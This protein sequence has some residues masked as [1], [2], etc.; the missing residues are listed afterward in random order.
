M[1]VLFE[2]LVIVLL[3]TAGWRQSFREHAIRIFPNAAFASKKSIYR[4]PPP[5]NII[6]PQPIET[7]PAPDPATSRRD[8]SWLWDKTPLDRR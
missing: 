6:Y 2:I 5:P 7:R 8:N 4:P 1:K 3:I